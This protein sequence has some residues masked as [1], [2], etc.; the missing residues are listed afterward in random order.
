MVV[1]MTSVADGP[2]FLQVKQVNASVLEAYAGKSNLFL[3]GRCSRNWDR[4][5]SRC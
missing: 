3:C 1:L 2:L 5:I 4:P